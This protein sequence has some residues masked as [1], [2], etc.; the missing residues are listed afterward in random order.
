MLN[1]FDKETAPLSE[2]ELRA[3]PTL[4]SALKQAYGKENAL[5]NQQLCRLAE[6]ITS[7]RLRKLINYIRQNGLVPCL[8]ASSKG[9]YVAETEQELL[10]YEDSLRGRE[11]AIREVREAIADQRKIRYNGALGTQGRLF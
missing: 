8:V 6:G 3:I 1:G 7:A 2:N 9:Y 11:A 4:V 5:Y 10:D